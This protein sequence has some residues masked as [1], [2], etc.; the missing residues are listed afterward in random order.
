MNDTERELAHAL[1]AVL[2]E[3]ENERE[4][5]PERARPTL[6][7]VLASEAVAQA[8]RALERAEVLR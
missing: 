5:G 1:R 8:R 7:R 2:V 6:S 3:I 4:E